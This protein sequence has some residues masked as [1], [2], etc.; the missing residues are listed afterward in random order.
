MVITEYLGKPVF[1]A[2]PPIFSTELQPAASHY[3][4]TAMHVS[5]IKY[6]AFIFF[7]S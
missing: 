3:A 4:C 1:H 2:Q 5:C 7:N 6:P